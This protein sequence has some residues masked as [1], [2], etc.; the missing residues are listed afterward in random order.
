MHIMSLIETAS[1]T[2]GAVCLQTGGG[3]RPTNPPLAQACLTAYESF[4]ET[5]HASIL[6]ANGEGTPPQPP[7]CFE[8]CAS[9]LDSL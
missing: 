2:M 6:F 5:N 4:F 9:L 1:F 7:R 3:V 8:P